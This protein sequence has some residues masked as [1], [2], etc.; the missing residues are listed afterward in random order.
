MMIMILLLM[1]SYSRRSLRTLYRCF[2]AVNNTT[3]VT[4]TTMLSLY[5]HDSWPWVM[6]RCDCIW[7]D[8]WT[9]VIDGMKLVC[10]LLRKC[11]I[12]RSIPIMFTD[13]VPGKHLSGWEPVLGMCT[14]FM[15]LPRLLYWCPLES[16]LLRFSITQVALMNSNLTNSS[17]I[18][19][20]CFIQYYTG[21]ITLR[22]LAVGH[23]P[24]GYRTVNT[25]RQYLA[26]K[27]R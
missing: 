20:N 26:F 13:Y 4:I 8:K 14:V 2:T 18:T 7:M 1:V 27:V 15:D 19:E 6:G 16:V 10:E 17:E 22:F 23:F 5:H 21:Y 24:A 12:L 9:F 11:L 3:E 25:E